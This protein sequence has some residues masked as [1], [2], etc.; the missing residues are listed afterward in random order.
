[1]D[2]QR[3]AGS[4]GHRD[5]AI[6]GPAPRDEVLG[7]EPAERRR[8]PVAVAPRDDLDAARVFAHV[9]ER[10]PDLQLGIAVEAPELPRVLMPREH[11]AAGLGLVE[12][13]RAIHRH[14]ARARHERPH[15]ALEQR[16]LHPR[17]KERVLLELLELAVAQARP[18]PTSAKGDVFV[19]A[20]LAVELKEEA[21][22]DH[23]AE[24]D[25]VRPLSQRLEP[26]VVE[27]PPEPRPAMRGEVRE[28]LSQVSLEGIGQQH[29]RSIT[30]PSRAGKQT[31][32][33]LP[34][35]GKGAYDGP[36]RPRSEWLA[37][38]VAVACHTAC[39]AV[40]VEPVA[41]LGAA[42]EDVVCPASTRW[43]GEVCVWRYVITDVR[44]PAMT[45]WDGSRCVATLVS[46]PEGSA[47]DS[48]RCV[49]IGEPPS[50]GDA[51]ASDQ[52]VVTPIDTM[53]D[54]RSGLPSRAP[55]SD[56]FQYR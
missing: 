34:D 35:M 42:Q 44:C 51:I 24:H 9:V 22:V 3:L 32:H 49:P 52:T 28:R 20:A 47:W 1:M 25:R 53:Y 19:A 12:Q 7:D 37:T 23:L 41:P 16:I 56:P 6:V 50:P 5:L 46:C 43:N 4:R 38:V 36:M 39:H 15:H 31:R 10:G 40:E 26:L 29:P 21:G 55:V 45:V 18:L 17:P 27:H 48:E 14:L 13:H 54:E 30:K 33:R 11:A 8:E 2:E